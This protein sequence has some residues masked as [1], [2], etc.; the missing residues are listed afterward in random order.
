VKSTAVSGGTLNPAA[1]TAEDGVT[2]AAIA[3]AIFAPLLA[4]AVSG[5]LI[6]LLARFIAK[7]RHRLS[8]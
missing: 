8:A 7:R 5:L 1:S 3:V 4:L 6:V 2:L